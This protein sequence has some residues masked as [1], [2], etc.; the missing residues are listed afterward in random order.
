MMVATWRRLAA[1]ATAALF[2]AGCFSTEHDAKL[3]RPRRPV[4]PYLSSDPTPHSV[5]DE[6]WH[7]AIGVNVCGVWQPGPTW[8]TVSSQGTLARYGSD[9]Y[10]GLHTHTLTT[11]KSDGLIHMEPARADEAGWNA[12]VGRYLAFGGWRFS[13]TAMMLW[14][15]ATGTPI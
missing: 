8:Q 2:L 11:G 13:T 4:G 15:G 7:A 6:H 10:A 5:K 3:V 14:P 12:T 1:A 9:E